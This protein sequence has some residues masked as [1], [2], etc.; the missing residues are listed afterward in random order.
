MKA[1][2]PVANTSSLFCSRIK[3][4]A[5]NHKARRDGTFTHSEDEA[6]GEETGKVLASGMAAQSNSPDEYV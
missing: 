5:D 6:G 4:G 1:L 3:H 2:T